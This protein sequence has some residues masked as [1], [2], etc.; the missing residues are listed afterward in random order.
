MGVFVLGLAVAFVWPNKASFVIFYATLALGI[1]YGM[2]F[3]GNLVVVAH[4]FPRRMGA[5]SGMMT[6]A[7]ALSAVAMVLPLDM[8]DNSIC[9]C[10]LISGRFS[11]HSTLQVGHFVL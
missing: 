10:E 8:V 7:Y 6:A 1:G 2:N 5:V 3:A 11:P 9:P 4:F